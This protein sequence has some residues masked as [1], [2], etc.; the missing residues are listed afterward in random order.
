MAKSNIQEKGQVMETLPSLFFR[1]R[2]ES[3]GEVLAHLAG[4]MK[5]NHIKI[6]PGDKVIIEMTPYDSRRGRIVY[7][8]K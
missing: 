3:G 2:L 6:L 7:R 1:V 5:L 8:L 4:K